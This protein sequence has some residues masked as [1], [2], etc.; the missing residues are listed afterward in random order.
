MPAKVVA[1]LTYYP[2][3]G[4]L[5]PPSFN[6]FAVI[7]HHHLQLLFATPF[8]LLL[9]LHVQS[10]VHILGIPMISLSLFDNRVTFLPQ[11][12]ST[13]MRG[14]SSSSFH[15]YDKQRPLCLTSFLTVF[16]I[17]FHSLW[18]ETSTRCLS[19]LDSIAEV[20]NQKC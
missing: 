5:S 12:P 19:R 13:H 7:S 4:K 8:K 3:N 6:I 1:D 15:S 16:C 17:F 10:F 11:L 20:L 14:H 2:R 9:S 18:L